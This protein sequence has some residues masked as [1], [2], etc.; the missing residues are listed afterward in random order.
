MDRILD[1][2]E[3]VETYFASHSFSSG[4]F[5]GVAF[6]IVS[7]LVVILLLFMLRSRRV[8]SLRL[9]TPKGVIVISASAVSDLIKSLESEFANL[10]IH[11]VQILKRHSR[12]SLDV[13]LDFA[14]GEQSLPETVLKLQTDSLSSLEKTFGVTNISSVSVKVRRTVPD[15]V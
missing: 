13:T 10:S 2:V 14:N 3:N 11:R 8:S 12:L 1:Y 7:L 5:S 15:A 9:T 4:Y 6:F